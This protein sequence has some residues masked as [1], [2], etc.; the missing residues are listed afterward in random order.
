MCSKTDKKKKNHLLELQKNVL[1]LVQVAATD[2]TECQNLFIQTL[3]LGCRLKHV[4]T[5]LK[6]KDATQT[7][8]N[9]QKKT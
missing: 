6:A 7:V 8:K 4:H 2:A 5:R 3:G 1:S 9:E